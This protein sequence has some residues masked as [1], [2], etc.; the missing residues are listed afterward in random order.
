MWVLLALAPFDFELNF[1]Q[2]LLGRHLCEVAIFISPDDVQLV[3]YGFLVPWDAFAP[4]NQRR[5][6]LRIRPNVKRILI[7]F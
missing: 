4:K 1:V 6:P 5:L 7:F 3:L 2:N